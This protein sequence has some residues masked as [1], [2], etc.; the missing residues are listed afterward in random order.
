MKEGCICTRELR[1]Q[2]RSHGGKTGTASIQGQEQ[3]QMR[4]GI[5]CAFFHLCTKDPDLSSTYKSAI[6][7]L[8]T[9]TLYIYC[10]V[11]SSVLSHA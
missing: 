3:N 5:Q 7:Q 4:V 6:K 11:E 9:K 8:P 2:Q 10:A 1:L